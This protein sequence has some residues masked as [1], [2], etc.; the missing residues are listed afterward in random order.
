MAE[1]QQT[2]DPAAGHGRLFALPLAV[3]AGFADAFGYLTL[4]GLLTAHV[5][6]NLVFMAAGLAQGNPHILVKFFAVPLFMLGV[7]LTTIVTTRLGGRQRRVL[8]WTLAAEAMLFLL[9]LL[10]G[11]VLPP[12]R[13]TDDLTGVTVGTIM[14]LAMGMQNAVMRMPLK[15]LPA[16]TAMTTNIS[17]ATVQWTHRLIGF[18]RPHKPEDRQALFDRAKT[19]GLTVS[20]FTIGTLGGAAAAVWLGYPGLAVPAGILLLLA[21]RAATYQVSPPAPMLGIL[22]SQA[23]SRE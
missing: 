3:T 10:A 6:G 5:T 23:N 14:I 15:A 1:G 12:C 2:E 4:H 16:T 20:A 19:I 9:G 17:E 21:L 8:A 13:T 11:E 18:G 7:S 22:P